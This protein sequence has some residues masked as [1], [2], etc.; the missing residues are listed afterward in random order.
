MKT[1]INIHNKASAQ[2]EIDEFRKKKYGKI[3]IKFI[4][5]H[6]IRINTYLRKDIFKQNMLY[7]IA[8]TLW[9]LMQPIGGRGMHNYHNLSSKE[10]VELLSNI[11]KP[12]CVF[13]DGMN[14][15]GIVSS[16]IGDCGE[17]LLVI[18]GVKVGLINNRNAKV[19]KIITIFPRGKVDKFIEEL[20]RKKLVLYCQ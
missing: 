3:D 10:I 15:Y 1:I 11:D 2:K 8:D 20:N 14:K 17:P 16:I 9:E 5:V 18:V 6:L 4:N 7:I 12:R 13:K 19:N